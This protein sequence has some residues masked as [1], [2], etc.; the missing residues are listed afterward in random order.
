M[1][2]KSIK[3]RNPD[4]RSASSRNFVPE[5]KFGFWFLGTHT[6]EQH[7]VQATLDD[8][9]RLIDIPRESYPVVLDAGC[10][11]GKAFH[12]LSEKFKPQQLI[13]VDADVRGLE[14]ARRVALRNKP[15]V[16]LLKGDCASLPLPEAYT[17]LVFCHQTFHHLVHQQQSLT[18]FYRVLKPGGVLL[19]AESTRAYIDTWLI[20]FLFR[21]PME[22][23]K[24]AQEYLHMI[25]QTGFLFDLHNVLF[26]YL[27][28][29][30][31][32]LL[33]LLELL[34]LRHAPPPAF[35]DETLVYLAAVKPG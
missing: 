33:G 7:V 4:E 34:K 5:S 16:T 20:R 26:P 8:L 32:T 18:E 21:H 6:W 1:D 23:Q 13:G 10:G 35:R 28:W 25:R 24:S 12:L 2:E 22:V 19:F 31:S 3:S 15:P 11:Q 9:A 29:S 27:W 17:D 30:R 14:H